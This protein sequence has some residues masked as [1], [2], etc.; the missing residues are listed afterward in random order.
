MA[1]PYDEKIGKLNTA[2]EN[3]YLK[4][5]NIIDELSTLLDGM[6][7]IE[8]ITFKIDYSS[9]GIVDVFRIENINDNVNISRDNNQVIF[10]LNPNDVANATLWCGRIMQWSKEYSLEGLVDSDDDG[11]I[12]ASISDLTE[13]TL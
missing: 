11:V 5:V 8:P 1:S 12:T 13:T 4:K 6:I 2:L 7:A 3:V 9:L 10:K